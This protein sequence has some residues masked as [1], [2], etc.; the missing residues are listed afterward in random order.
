M[1][2]AKENER[3]FD[4]AKAALLPIHHN[5]PRRFNDIHHGTAYQGIES[6]NLG[7]IPETPSDEAISTSNRPE[8]IFSAL[9]DDISSLT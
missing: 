7:E 5:I 6:S 9:P 4:V 8:A 1:L 2:E 3:Y